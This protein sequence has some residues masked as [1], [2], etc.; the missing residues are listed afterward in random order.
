MVSLTFRSKQTLLP[1]MMVNYQIGNGVVESASYRAGSFRGANAVAPSFCLNTSMELPHPDPSLLQP[2]L[3]HL[4][5][6]TVPLLV[7]N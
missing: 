6:H 2:A 4:C 7:A 3:C 5:Y 1:L